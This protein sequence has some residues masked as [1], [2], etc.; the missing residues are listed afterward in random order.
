MANRQDLR[1]DRDVLVSRLMDIHKESR[2]MADS[3][4]ERC[5]ALGAQMASLGVRLLNKYGQILQCE[6]CEA[7]W[8]PQPASDGS[9]PLGFWRCPNRC[10][11]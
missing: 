1:L 4:D 11:W 10:N 9:F 8:T 6:A 2:E 3:Q 5:R 7:T